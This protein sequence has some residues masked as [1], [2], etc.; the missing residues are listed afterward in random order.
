MYRI[1]FYNMGHYS[2]NEGASLEAAKV[3]ARKAGFQSVIEFQGIPVMTFCPLAGF[4]VY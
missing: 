2:Q 4:Q 1:F 3:I